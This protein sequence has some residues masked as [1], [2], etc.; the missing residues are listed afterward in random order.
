MSCR[1]G[2]PP[3]KDN[4][5]TSI[6][7]WSELDRDTGFEDTTA[8]IIGHS[9]G[10]SSQ[11]PFLFLSPPSEVGARWS[12]QPDLGEMYAQS[13]EWTQAMTAKDFC[14]HPRQPV[15]VQDSQ[16]ED[17]CPP[18]R[19]EHHNTLTSHQTLL[20]T[21]PNRAQWKAMRARWQW[22][23]TKQS[24]ICMLFPQWSTLPQE[25]NGTDGGW[26]VLPMC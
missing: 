7:H 21:F 17:S 12:N 9:Q 4:A 24:G 22:P 19:P 25:N 14:V 5:W 26:L 15:L 10:T 6:R 8:I 2:E 1:V 18:Y 11:S 3:C 20:L 16:L 23:V 13:M